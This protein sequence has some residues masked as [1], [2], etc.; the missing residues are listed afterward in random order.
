LVNEVFPLAELMDKQ[1]SWRLQLP[2]NSPLAITEAIA[3]VNASYILKT[4]LKRR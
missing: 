2:K 3:A 1:K 4:D